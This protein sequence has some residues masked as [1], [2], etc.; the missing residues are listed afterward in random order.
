MEWEG[1]TYNM[2]ASSTSILKNGVEIFNSGDVR[3]NGD[4]HVWTATTTAP[5]SWMSW[6]DPVIVK[7]GEDLPPPTPAYVPWS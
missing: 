7:S 6:V 2:S 3:D 5:L 4:V 1:R